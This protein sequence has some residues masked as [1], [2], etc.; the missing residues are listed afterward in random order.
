MID[1]SPGSGQADDSRRAGLC[2]LCLHVRV[3]TSDR[4]SRFYMCGRSTT[5]PRF[6]RYPAIPVVACAGFDPA[7]RAE[8]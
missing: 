8:G 7:A 2:G 6:P 4:G 5:D 1:D 3:I